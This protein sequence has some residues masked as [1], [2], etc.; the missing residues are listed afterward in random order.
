MAEFFE[1][2]TQ[3]QV[4]VDFA[5]ENDAPFAGVF[6]NRLIAALEIDDFQARGA[7]GEGFGG[8]GALLVGPTMTQGG[9]GLLN[10]PVRSESIFMRKT[11]NAAQ[12]VPLFE[13]SKSASLRSTA[14]NFRRFQ[15]WR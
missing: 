13:K 5:V 9:K 2:G 7:T 1:F 14:G 12:A 8:E 6:E 15:R 11:G 10:A 4:I 3:F